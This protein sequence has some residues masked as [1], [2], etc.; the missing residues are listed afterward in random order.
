[1]RF[2]TWA[3][4]SGYAGGDRGER[5]PV[6]L[7]VVQRRD[8]HAAHVGEVAQHARPVAGRP[9]PGEHRGDLAGDLLAVAEDER[10]DEVGE[11]LRV[12]GAVPAGDHE[13]VVVAALLGAHGDTGQVDAV[14]Q[15]RVHE[16]GGEVEGEDVEGPGGAVRLEG[17]E[18]QAPGSQHRLEV[19]PGGVGALGHRV[20]AFVEDLVEDLEA[21]VR[22][23]DFVGVGVDEQPG[24]LTRPMVGLHAP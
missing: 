24:D 17:E 18:R 13:G 11:R 8:V 19:D 22:Q 2:S 10:V 14:Q 20:G 5:R 23:A 12:V 3:G 7:D 1:M 6:V 21:L 9:V 16:L 15:V 4:T